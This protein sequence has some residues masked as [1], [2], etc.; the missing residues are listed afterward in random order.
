MSP[1]VRPLLFSVALTLMLTA[2][3]SLVDTPNQ[4]VQVLTPGATG[5]RCE[6]KN[7]DV[8]YVAHPPETIMMRRISTP[9]NVICDAPGNRT[10]TIVVYPKLN[11]STLG[12]VT[13]A[14]LGSVYDYISGAIHEIPS[15]ITVDFRHTIATHAPMPLY[16]NSDTISPFSEEPE[17]MREAE[18]LHPG[19]QNLPMDS[20]PLREDPEPTQDDLTKAPG[21][22][23]PLDPKTP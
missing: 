11:T 18:Y 16:H 3:A 17:D 22:D 19:E 7:N 14:G 9:L 13:T 1:V 4:Q 12:N 5:A 8:Q 20:A 6:I 23:L 10:K 15:P 21:L 2:C